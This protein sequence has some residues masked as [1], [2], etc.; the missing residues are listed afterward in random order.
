MATSSIGPYAPLEGD[1]RAQ[2]LVVGAGI[3]GLAA[4]LE[5]QRRGLEVVVLEK[6]VVGGGATGFTTAKLSALHGSSAYTQI[7]GN[8]GEEAA[9]A[10]AR[11]NERGLARIRELGIDCD[12][13][14]RPNLVYAADASDLPTLQDEREAARRAGLA[15]E[16]V[17][18]AGLPYPVAGALR[19]DGQAEFHPRKFLAGL[20]ER[21]VAGG[22]R[23]HEGTIVRSLRDGR[24]ARLETPRGTVTAD[25]VV[26]ASH[27]PFA[28]RA[29]VWARAHPERSYSIAVRIAEAPPQVMA[30]SASSPTRSIRAHPVGDGELL[31]VGGEGHKVGTGGPTSERYR[32]LERFAREHWTVRSVD[33]RWSTQDWI[34]ADGLPLIGRLTP[35]AKAAWTATGYR[36][37]G[38]AMGLAAGE[39]LAG[40]IAGDPAPELEHF[41]P[42]R[43]PPL[44]ALP[45]LAKENAQAGLHFFADR[46]TRRGRSSQELAPGEGRVVS[47]H[48]RQVAVS[49][50]D[51]GVLRAVSARCTHVGCIVAFNDA[52]RSW[53]CPCHG[54]RFA[55]DGSVLEG[56]ATSP[57]RP[58]D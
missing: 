42:N 56:P 22:G 53:D 16:L 35:R 33:Y 12:L 36:K 28:D 1:L 17:D 13:R 38:L 57:L 51:D 4:A 21:L 44:R 9:A 43:R 31:L 10:Y 49:R 40:A 45:E 7:E 30:I 6:G 25:H 27:I 23:I 2:A 39:L 24:P 48:G 47:R 50:D 54:S 3:T 14:E 18:T 15:V 52:E 58:E 11:V 32:A 41:T 19:L 37:W 26:L 34:P 29:L 8:H 46:L 55:L 5:L 20:A